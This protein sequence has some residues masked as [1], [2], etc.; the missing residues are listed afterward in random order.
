MLSGPA[1]ARFSPCVRRCQGSALRAD[2]A[3]RGCGLDIGEAQGGRLIL[4]VP[5]VSRS[6]IPRHEAQLQRSASVQNDRGESFRLEMAFARSCDSL[7]PHPP[8]PELLALDS[9]V[10][11]P[12]VRARDFPVRQSGAWSGRAR[13]RAIGASQETRSPGSRRKWPLGCCRRSAQR[14]SIRLADTEETICRHP[15]RHAHVSA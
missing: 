1:P 10:S 11:L 14:P 9:C 6:T 15:R 7:H 13:F 2:P 4:P 8:T 5:V 12:C 3:V